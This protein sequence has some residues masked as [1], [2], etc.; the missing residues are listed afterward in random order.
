MCLRLG[1][2]LYQG[3]SGDHQS[4][5]SR[6]QNWSQLCGSLLLRCN[7]GNSI[8]AVIIG[9]VAVV[10]VVSASIVVLPSLSVVGREHGCSGSEPIAWH[11][12]EVG[13]HRISE[14]V[15][16]DVEI[17]IPLDGLECA[18]QNYDRQS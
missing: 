12:Q 3:G 7:D 14:F 6:L 8:P 2:H 18:H 13:V 17:G 4:G 5:A 1:T 15:G 16:L 10:P 9:L 11:H